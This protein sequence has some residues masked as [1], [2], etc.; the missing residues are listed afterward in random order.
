[1]IILFGFICGSQAFTLEVEDLLENPIE[2]IADHSNSGL[3]FHG[4]LHNRAADIWTQGLKPFAHGNGWGVWTTSKWSTAF[5]F[6]NLW[7]EH[8]YPIVLIVDL[9]SVDHP[10]FLSL[11]RNR[12]QKHIKKL[13]RKWGISSQ[14]RTEIMQRLAYDYHIDAVEKDGDV[15]LLRPNRFRLFSFEETEGFYRNP[16]MKWLSEATV[17]SIE[18][19][20]CSQYLLGSSKT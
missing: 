11:S 20:K 16:K 18:H 8:Q 3:V 5:E 13:A 17:R 9:N 10:R 15:I 19:L 1:M 2:F 6:G 4:T 12:T 14:D 7:G